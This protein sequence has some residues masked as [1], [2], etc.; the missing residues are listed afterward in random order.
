MKMY[1]G[2]NI[3]A[4]REKNKMTQAE[5]AKRCGVSSK[6]VW[7]WEANRTEP[8][9]GAVQKML[10][11]FDCSAEDLCKQI[12]VNISYEEYVLLDMYRMAPISERKHLEEYAKFLLQ[13][14]GK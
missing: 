7:S 9:A 12:N 1:I 4:Y 10:Q 8:S 11:I 13:R 5:L 14:E 6:L 3:R 2:N